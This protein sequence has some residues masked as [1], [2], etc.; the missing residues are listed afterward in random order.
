MQQDRL[1][2][3]RL[4]PNEHV[5]NGITVHRQLQFKCMEQSGHH[6][7]PSRVDMWTTLLLLWSELDPGF[8]T[9]SNNDFKTELDRTGLQAT[10]QEISGHNHISPPLALMTILQTEEEWGA[11]TAEWIKK[12]SG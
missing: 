10:A 11:S 7:Q 8:I 3:L 1:L 9:K 5:S 6:S 12:Q 4:R 2:S